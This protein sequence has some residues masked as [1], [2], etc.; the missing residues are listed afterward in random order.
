MSY[1]D[2]YTNEK[3]IPYV[4]EPS[5]GVERLFLAILSNAYEQETLED[6]TTRDVLRLTFDLAPFKVCVLPLVKKLDDDAKKVF[7]LLKKE[8]NTDYDV[9]GNIGKRYRRQDVIGTPF[10]ITYDY[11]SQNDN[12]VTVRHRDSMKQE[13][14]EIN[15]L[16]DYIKNNK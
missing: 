16:I 2:P 11:D 5:V 6:N 3:Y 14:I 7:D 4:I 1:L 12:C 13:R 15:D 9:S 10:C 8:F